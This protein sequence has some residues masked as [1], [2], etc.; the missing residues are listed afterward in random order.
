MEIMSNPCY[1]VY[2]NIKCRKNESHTHFPDKMRER[3]K[4]RM[5]RDDEKGW[6]ENVNLIMRAGKPIR[7][8]FYTLQSSILQIPEKH[9]ICIKLFHEMQSATV[10]RNHILAKSLPTTSLLFPLYC[11][12]D[13]YMKVYYPK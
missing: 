12:S 3:L 7:I 9:Y 1:N 6:S 11:H 4:L 5:Q 10:Q 2:T 8:L 13:R